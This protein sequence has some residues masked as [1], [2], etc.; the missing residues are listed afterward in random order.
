MEKNADEIASSIIDMLK[1]ERLKQGISHEKLARKCGLHRSAIS[2]IESK[3]R[4]PSMLNCIKIA[5][6]L[7]IDLGK[8]IERELNAGAQG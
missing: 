7:D 6:A 5:M 1:Y 2:L 4:Q 3:K 8:F